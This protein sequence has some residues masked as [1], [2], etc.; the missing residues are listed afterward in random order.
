MKVTINLCYIVNRLVR[1]NTSLNAI[2]INSA[3]S[4]TSNIAHTILYANI[5]KY[6]Q[7]ITLI[8]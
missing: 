3:S 7:K 6:S 5:K 4:I 8:S 1:E 2:F